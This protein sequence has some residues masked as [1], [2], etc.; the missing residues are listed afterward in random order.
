[1]EEYRLEIQEKKAELMCVQLANTE[2]TRKREDFEKEKD[3]YKAQLTQ[4]RD[5]IEQLRMSL[6]AE[7]EALNV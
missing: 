7:R 1:M 3:Y 4:M 6:D 2:D 5:E